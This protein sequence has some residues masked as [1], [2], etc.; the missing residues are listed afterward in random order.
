MKK[1]VAI[2]AWPLLAF[3][4]L[5]DLSHSL[6]AQQGGSNF[7]PATTVQLPVFGVAVNPDGVL[8]HM[9]F[10]PAGGALFLERARAVIQTMDADLLSASP[11]RK[12]SLKQLQRTIE[13]AL[14]QG[15]QLPDAVQKLAGLQRIQYVFAYPEQQDIVLAGP[16]EGWVENAGGRFVGISSGRP[17]VL[18]EDLLT[19]LR[20]FQGDRPAN[21]WVG[22]S[23]GSTT[24]G[25]RRL[26]ELQKELPRRVASGEEQRLARQIVPAIEEALGNAGIT[27]FGVPPRTHMAH[28][29]LE[30]DYRMKLIA[31]GREPPPISMPTFFGKLT[32]RHG[33]IFNVGGSHPTINV[34]S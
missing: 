14:S 16:A 17:V 22:C 18:L 13:E 32:A 10:A 31:I 21:T 2:W 5:Q 4:S 7:Q 12:V 8:Q 3:L 6:A 24:E 30:A 33:I 28:V 26:A 9:Q 19:A 29:L 27:V 25:R 11:L 34:W 23:I 20:V 15:Q 1:I